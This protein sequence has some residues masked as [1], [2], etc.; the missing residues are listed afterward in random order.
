ML[1][2]NNH[3][4]L[5]SLKKKI[6]LGVIDVLIIGWLKDGQLCGHEIITKIKKEYGISFSSGTVYPILFSLRDKGIVDSTNDGKKT[7]FRLTPKGEMLSKKLLAYC[8][9]I[10]DGLKKDLNNHN[11]HKNNLFPKEYLNLVD[12]LYEEK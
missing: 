11:S 7:Y 5:S 9:K 10:T 3:A 6:V 12:T 1:E 4:Y 8:E 2:N